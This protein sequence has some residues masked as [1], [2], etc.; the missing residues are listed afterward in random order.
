[1]A[2]PKGHIIEEQD[3]PQLL[4]LGKEHIYVWENDDSM[5]HENEAAEILRDICLGRNIRA[6]AP[7]EGKIELIAAASGLLT[8]ESERLNAVN[9]SLATPGTI[10][11]ISWHSAWPAASAVFSSFILPHIL[12]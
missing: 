8:V 3:I 6:T 7:K 2:F 4:R 9:S 10:R 1:V 5:L 12:Y 11:V